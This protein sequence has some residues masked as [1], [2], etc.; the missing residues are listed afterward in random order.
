MHSKFPSYYFLFFP[1][2][3]KERSFIQSFFQ[4]S[5]FFDLPQHELHAA[6][7][8]FCSVMATHWEK[9]QC[10]FRIVS[11]AGHAFYMF[12]FIMHKG[13]YLV[14]IYVCF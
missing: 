6:S 12:L 14:N 10:F 3:S 8:V 9:Q 1:Y 13:C 4:F 5:I 11:L 2:M 7:S